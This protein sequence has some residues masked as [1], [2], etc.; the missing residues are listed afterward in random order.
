MRDDSER[1]Q[2]ILE[3]IVQIEKYAVRGREEFERDELLQVWMVHHLQI[4]GEAVRGLSEALRESHRM[5]PWA[6]I[7]AMRNILVHEYFDVDLDEVWA[8]VQRDLPA[9]KS[10]VQ[11]ILDQLADGCDREVGNQ[12]E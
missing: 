11:Q 5:V 2:D 8:T 9:L 7:G 3:A 12:D 10:G 4:I 6:Q 1:L